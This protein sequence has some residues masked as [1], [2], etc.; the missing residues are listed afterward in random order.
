MRRPRAAALAV[1][2]S[3]AL[4]LAGPARAEERVEEPVGATPTSR[5]RPTLLWM[6]T[7]LVPS[8]ELA[9]GTH[10]ALAGLG[11]QVTPLVYSFGLHR[12]APKWRMFV[13]DPMARQSGSIELYAAPELFAQPDW[14]ITLRPGIRAYHG[15]VARGEWL[16][17]SLGVSYQPGPGRESAAFDLGLHGYAGVVGLVA[18]IAPMSDLAPF[19]LTFRFRYF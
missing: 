15:L 2:V 3:L 8:G 16:S 19:M 17:A 4:S 11:W 13:V 5:E 6:A 18:T 7:Q 1:S 9:V 14:S 12:R 10:G